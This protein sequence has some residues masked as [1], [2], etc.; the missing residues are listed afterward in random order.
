MISAPR[1]SILLAQAA[2]LIGRACGMT[3]AAADPTMREQLSLVAG[4]GRAARS[5]LNAPEEP[6]DAAVLREIETVLKT[7]AAH[8]DHIERLLRARAGAK[9]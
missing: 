8:L 4:V 2:G 9:P 7:Q 5:T 3:H 1:A 6:T